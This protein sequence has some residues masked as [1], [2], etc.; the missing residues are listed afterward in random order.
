VPTR[1]DSSFQRLTERSQTAV[2]ELLQD[3]EDGRISRQRFQYA[4][5]AVIARSKADATVFGDVAMAAILGVR[6][7]GIPP[8]VQDPSRWV[9][10]SGT[11]L[12]F[13]PEMEDLLVSRQLRF[14]RLARAET[15]TQA[16]DTMQVSMRANN[17]ER[18][19]RQTDN[20]PCPL[21]V[22]LADGVAR[23]TTVRMARHE[24]CV[25]RQQPVPQRQPWGNS[26]WANVNPTIREQWAA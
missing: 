25:C 22:E 10:A 2:L 3:F 11:I 13:E 14:A 17:V 8:N 9:R 20:E 23:P 16:Q 18:W 6:P 19:I 1:F 24:G 21:C 7:L 26:G 12:D 15:A 4:V 5:A